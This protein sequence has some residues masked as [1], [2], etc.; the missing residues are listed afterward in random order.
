[1]NTPFVFRLKGEVTESLPTAARQEKRRRA[2][3]NEDI[4]TL[5]PEHA[6][7]VLVQE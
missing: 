1:M 3:R 2:F 6:L 7:C 5:E 4:G